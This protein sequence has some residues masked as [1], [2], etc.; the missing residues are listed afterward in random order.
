M[1]CFL[2]CRGACTLKMKSENARER[3]H[4]C[5]RSNHI[6]LLRASSTTWI[7]SRWLTSRLDHVRVTRMDTTLIHLE[8]P[9]DVRIEFDLVPLPL[10]NPASRH[11][12]ELRQVREVEL[13]LRTWQRGAH[14]Q[15]KT[16]S[17]F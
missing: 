8:P 2:T 12:E 16:E 10:R 9:G 15:P 17:G 11:L 3:I 5:S 1:A 6:K 7:I 13:A 4:F 14:P